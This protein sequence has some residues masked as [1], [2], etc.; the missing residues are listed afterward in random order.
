MRATQISRA[1]LSN[2]MLISRRR[3][4]VLHRRRMTRPRVWYIRESSDGLKNSTGIL[5]CMA[6]IE[7]TFE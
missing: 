7:S 2:M 4:S 3:Q 1:V 5:P 6:F